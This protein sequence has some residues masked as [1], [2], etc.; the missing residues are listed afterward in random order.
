V[1][2]TPAQAVPDAGAARAALLKFRDRM[3]E[4][5]QGK[6]TA[7]R[8]LDSEVP[9]IAFDYDVPTGVKRISGRMYYSAAGIYI[10]LA[11]GKTEAERFF[12]AFHIISPAP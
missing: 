3:G 12:A 8:V 5:W 10:V 2:H 7:E 9:G 1:I 11:K 4:T 6:L